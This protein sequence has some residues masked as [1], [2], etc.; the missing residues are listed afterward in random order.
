MADHVIG[1][2]IVLLEGFLALLELPFRLVRLGLVKVAPAVLDRMSY[3]LIDAEAG[4]VHLVQM[5]KTD[6]LVVVVVTEDR[7]AGACEIAGVV[8]GLERLG[9]HDH[10]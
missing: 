2:P 7:R 5:I 3:V 6:V 4:L 9:H 8:V 1:S 10:R